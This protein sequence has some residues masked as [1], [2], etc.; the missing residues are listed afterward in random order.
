MK[1][2]NLSS[3]I[4]DAT[5]WAMRFSV[6]IPAYNEARTIERAIQATRDAL[7]H[8]EG[9]AEIIVVDDGSSDGTADRVYGLRNVRVIRHDTNQ[10]KGKAVKTGVLAAQ[11]EWIIFLDA[12]LS[13]QPS[14]IKN[15][16]PLLDQSDV[17]IGSRRVHHAEIPEPQPWHRDYSGRL[18]NIAVRLL[19][20]LP[21]RD[22]QCGFKAFH[23][24][25]LSIFSLL[26]TSGWA[27][28]VELLVRARKQGFRVNEIPV[29]WRHGRES[30]VRWT[31]AV[32]II[33]ELWRIR[34]LAG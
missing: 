17:I 22:T 5:L 10:G 6:V 30:R 25:T 26:E 4:T 29:T 20:G 11:G 23:R 13:V 32:R 24:R 34:T 12:D 18:F 14:A 9:G 1:K 8:L 2:G 21:Y 31:H 33:R 3:R 15:L 28:D 19:T 16:L 7:A 27:F